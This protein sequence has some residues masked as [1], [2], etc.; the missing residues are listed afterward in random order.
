MTFG[1][2]GLG[3]RMQG[4][5]VLFRQAQLWDRREVVIVSGVLRLRICDLGSDFDFRI[6]RAVPNH[7]TQS[8]LRRITSDP[9]DEIPRVPVIMRNS[10]TRSAYLQRPNLGA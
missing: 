9:S 1:V 3:F 7:G 6:Y 4:L 5:G 10:G 2:Q 8:I